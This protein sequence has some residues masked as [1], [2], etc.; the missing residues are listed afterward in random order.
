[1]SVNQVLFCTHCHVPHPTLF[2]VTLGKV[3]LVMWLG[4]LG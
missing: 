4:H 2:H 3:A 1:M